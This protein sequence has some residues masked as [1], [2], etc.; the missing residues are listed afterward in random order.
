MHK[1][2]APKRTVLNKVNRFAVHIDFAMLAVR[3]R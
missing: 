2:H 1:A 3:E